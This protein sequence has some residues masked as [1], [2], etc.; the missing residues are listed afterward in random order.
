MRPAAYRDALPPTLVEEIEGEMTRDGIPPDCM[1]YLLQVNYE[2]G[3]YDHRV[4]VRHRDDS[5]Q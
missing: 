4:G 1:K 5:E 2:I 3:L